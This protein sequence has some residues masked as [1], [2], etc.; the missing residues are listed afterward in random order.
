MPILEYSGDTRSIAEIVAA[1]PPEQRLEVLSGFDADV[2]SQL[3]HNWDFWGRPKQQEPGLLPSGRPYFCWMLLAGRGFGKTATGAQWVKR[4][5]LAARE[6]KQ[7]IRIALIAETAADARDVM[8]EGDSGII[9]ESDPDFMPIYQSSKRKVTWPDGSVAH[10]FSGEEPGQLRGPQFHYAWVDELAKYLYPDDTWDNLEFGLRLGDTPQV[11]V[12]TTPRPIPIVVAIHDDPMNVVTVGSSYENIGNLAPSY[13]NRVLK[14]YEGTRLGE[15]ELHAKIL[16]DVPGALWTMDMLTECRIPLGELPSS[17]VRTTISV[18]PAV[19]TSEKANETGIIV[20]SRAE[21]GHAFVRKDASGEF[22]ASEWAKVAIRQYRNFE[23]S[24]MVGEAN[25]GGDLVESN[26][27][28]HDKSI[29][30]RKVW[31]V[32]SKGQRAEPIAALYEQGKIHHVGQFPDLESQMM[33]ITRE[34]YFGA[35]SPDR[36]DALV[37]GASDVMFG[38][39]ASHNPQDYATSRF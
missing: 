31:A 6:R 30:F 29:H 26:V 19:S 2:L 22:T 9:A 10:T 7:P 23:A 39:Q 27:K 25:N 1:M 5:V 24:R 18:D 38:A 4:R 13:I 28:A 12:T 20:I 34:E 11:C 17:I 21:N 33:L 32:K 14:K 35:G 16:R 15:Q 3:T 37:W 36:L 8:I